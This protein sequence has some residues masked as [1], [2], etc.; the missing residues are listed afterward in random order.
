MIKYIF[1][2]NIPEVKFPEI[3][4]GADISWFGTCLICPDKE[5]KQK[6]VK[7]LENNGIQ[8]RDFFGKNILTQPG[9]Q[10][11]GNWKDY[12]VANDILY[13]LFFVGANPNYTTENFTYLENILENYV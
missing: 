9:F 6:L 8:T 13:R 7:Y 11:F 5:F 1:E 10:K 2:Q 3:L 4:P 12:P